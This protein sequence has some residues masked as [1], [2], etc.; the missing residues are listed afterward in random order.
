MNKHR[1][2]EESDRELVFYIE[3]SKKSLYKGDT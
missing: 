2:R 1:G 3:S